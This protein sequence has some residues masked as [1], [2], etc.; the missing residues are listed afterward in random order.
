LVAVIVAFAMVNFVSGNV[1][2]GSVLLGCAALVPVL[3]A[4]NHGLSRR[5]GQRAAVGWSTLLTVGIAA[6]AWAGVVVTEDLGTRIA[7]LVC[8]LCFT[9]VAAV[10]VLVI[11]KLSL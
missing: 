3:A 2:S 5:F 11:R 4:V 7:C 9:V 1:R 8:A 6:A 10:G